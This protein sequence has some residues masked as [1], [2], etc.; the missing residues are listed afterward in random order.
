MPLQ[1]L[2]CDAAAFARIPREC[3]ELHAPFL[4][5]R[6]WALHRRL[7]HGVRRAATAHRAALAGGSVRAL[8][9]P[10]GFV[11]AR[12]SSVPSCEAHGELAALLEARLSRMLD[13]RLGGAPLGAPPRIGDV[14][15]VGAVSSAAAPQVEVEFARV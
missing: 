5:V 10:S 3:P 6:V 12:A 15:A 2:C 14:P 7:L 13:D 1:A 8:A 4:R 9:P 11:A